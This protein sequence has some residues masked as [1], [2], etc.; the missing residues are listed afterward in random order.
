MAECV[1][2]GNIGYCS[3]EYNIYMRQDTA[4]GT[5][6][7]SNASYVMLACYAVHSLISFTMFIWLFTMLLVAHKQHVLKRDVLGFAGVSTALAWLFFGLDSLMFLTSITKML[8]QGENYIYAT[9]QGLYVMM[10]VMSHVFFSL[11]VMLAMTRTLKMMTGESRNDFRN[12]VLAASALGVILFT[13]IAYLTAVQMYALVAALSCIGLLVTWITF[14]IAT[15]RL[16][17][18]LLKTSNQST[19]VLMDTVAAI[20]VASRRIALSVVGCV[21]SATLYV[22]AFYIGR[23]KL[24]KFALGVGSALPLGMC[25]VFLSLSLGFLSHILIHLF[26]SKFDCTFAKPVCRVIAILS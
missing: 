25:W 6:E 7:L 5:C 15:I 24:S 4:H 16:E 17:R 22:L 18:V 20:K 26:L 12:S 8:S 21:I 13:G 2:N 3:C 14:S 23:L 10:M 19:G 9:I 11:S 1:T